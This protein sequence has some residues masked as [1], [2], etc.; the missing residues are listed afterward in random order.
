MYTRKHL[1]FVVFGLLVA[2]TMVIPSTVQGQIRGIE[3]ADRVKIWAP[4]YNLSAFT[5]RVSSIGSDRIELVRNGRTFVVPY[6]YVERLWVSQGYRRNTGTGA[7]IGGLA[8][9]LG[10]GIIAIAINDESCNTDEFLDCTFVMSD[11]PAFLT[12]AAL[13]GLAGI[14]VG[15]ITGYNINTEQWKLISVNW[16]VVRARLPKAGQGGYTALKLQLSF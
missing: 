8:G 3:N 11:G 14:L 7:L 4:H 12:G 9:G 13:G 10:L 15:S 16:S 6:K 5:G 2:L 1:S